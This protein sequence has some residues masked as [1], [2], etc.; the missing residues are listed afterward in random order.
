MTRV[1]CWNMNYRRA[2]WRTLA[3]MGA[4]VALLQEPC[5][6][7]PDA[8]DGVEISLPSLPEITSPA[9]LAAASPPDLFTG[10]RSNRLTW[11]FTAAQAAVAEGCRGP[12][13]RSCGPRGRGTHRPGP[14]R[15]PADRLRPRPRADAGVRGG[16]PGRRPRHLPPA[17]ASS[18]TRSPSSAAASTP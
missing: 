2:S 4:D 15:L 8:A 18:P 6:V 13:E 7:P 12:L 5:K 9:S 1:V 14:R 3:Q 17:A 10:H 16:G 11:C